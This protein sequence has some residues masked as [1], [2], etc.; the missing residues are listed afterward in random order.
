[1]SYY[2]V[3]EDWRQPTKRP[4][5][6]THKLWPV[7]FTVYV[8]SEKRHPQANNLKYCPAIQDT[9]RDEHSLERG[10]ALYRSK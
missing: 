2:N 9:S 4:L 3:D 1:M 10:A 6:Q 5:W 8:Y 7:V